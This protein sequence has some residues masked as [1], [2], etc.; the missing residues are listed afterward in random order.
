MEALVITLGIILLIIGFVSSV[1]P[2]LPGPP[3]AF[4]ALLLIHFAPNEI[5]FQTS[6]LIIIGLLSVSVS[7]LDNFVA[8][9]GTH[10]FG[11][12]KAGVRGSFIGLLLGVVLTPITGG[13]SIILG[14]VAGAIAGEI[15]AGQ[16]IEV[17]IRSG[18][19]S[20]VGF[21]LGLGMKLILISYITFIFFKEIF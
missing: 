17:A 9:W 1:L 15:I 3:V 21:I 18:F 13:V 20:F 4:L 2:P 5:S 12:T 8:I 10:K 19:G 11:G 14:P 6:T 7:I 16:N